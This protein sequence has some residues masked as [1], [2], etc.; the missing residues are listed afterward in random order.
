MKTNWKL[1]FLLP[2][3][4]ALVAGCGDDDKKDAPRATQTVPVVTPE[5]TKESFVKAI[6]DEVKDVDEQIKKLEKKLAD[7]KL[8]QN[9]NAWRKALDNALAENQKKVAALKNASDN[10]W[11]KAGKEVTASLT[12]LKSELASTTDKVK[13]YEASK[14]RFDDQRETIEKWKVNN[15]PA[16]NDTIKGIREDLIKEYEDLEEQNANIWKEQQ[17]KF[18]EYRAQF[19]AKLDSLEKRITST[20]DRD[21][22]EGKMRTA[23]NDMEKKAGELREKIAEKQGDAR[24]KLEESLQ[25]LEKERTE[26]QSNLK[27]LSQAAADKWEAAKKDFQSRM[28]QLQKSWDEFVKAFD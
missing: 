26:L 10:D 24:T 3:G 7:A 6:D 21:E 28:E 18:G 4:A 17:D 5:Q 2:L 9:D 27:E 23:I 25:K 14:K 22:F 20:L 13:L 1:A 16:A 11:E 12:A 15:P 8:P 19:N